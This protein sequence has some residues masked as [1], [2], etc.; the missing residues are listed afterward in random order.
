[1]VKNILSTFVMLV[2]LSLQGYILKQL[3][4]LPTPSWD[5]NTRRNAYPIEYEA[6]RTNTIF[7]III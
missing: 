6:I 7:Y 3:F 5:A 1:M 2:D 4:K